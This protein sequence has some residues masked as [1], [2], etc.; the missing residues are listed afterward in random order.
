MILDIKKAGVIALPFDRNSTETKEGLATFVI[1]IKDNPEDRGRRFCMRF[2]IRFVTFKDLRV[3]FASRIRTE[4]EL[5]DEVFGEL[6]D[7][8]FHKLKVNSVSEEDYKRAYENLFN[9][10]YA[11]YD[12]TKVYFENG[13]ERYQFVESRK[14]GVINY[15]KNIKEAKKYKT[16]EKAQ[17]VAQKFG[18]TFEVFTINPK[19]NKK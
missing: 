16:L 8:V 1:Y 7:L 5:P 17:L 11:L 12:I 9:P 10:L 4:T 3:K 15:T 19:R 18:E 14:N 13:V 2:M 6:L